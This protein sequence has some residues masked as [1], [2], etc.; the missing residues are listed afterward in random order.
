[1][2]EDTKNQK[3][4]AAPKLVLNDRD[5]FYLAVSEPRVVGKTSIVYT[6]VCLNTGG[7]YY[8]MIPRTEMASFDN[9]GDANM[10]YNA[11]SEMGRYQHKQPTWE[12]F[13]RIL[14]ADKYISIFHQ[15]TR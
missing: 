7:S 6:L 4:I 15:N 11:V 8:E 13:R 3:Q 5:K 1:M 14:D 12:S 9:P 2:S 10:F